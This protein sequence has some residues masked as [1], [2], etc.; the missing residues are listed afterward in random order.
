MVASIAEKRGPGRPKDLEKRAVIVAA[1][2]D[3][4]FARGVEAVTIDAIAAQAGVSKMTVYASFKD[5]AALFAE[6]VRSESERMEGEFSEDLPLGADLRQTLVRFGIV[7]MTFL[8]RPDINAF[9]R[10]F[11]T[12]APRHPDLARSMFENGPGRVRAILTDVIEQQA[13]ASGLIIADPQ[14]AAEDLAALWLGMTPIEIR[15]GVGAFPDQ[16]AIRRR[17]EHGVGLFMKAYG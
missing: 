16:A 13:A 12:E 11:A 5:K 2:R 15:F 4:F 6:V 3:L 14:Q 9:D 7:L 10:L 17:V 8:M 1:A